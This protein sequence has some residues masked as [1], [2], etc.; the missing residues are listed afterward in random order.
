MTLTRSASLSS[1]GPAC[2]RRLGDVA[3]SVR[4]A[5][6]SASARPRAAP[7]ADCSS[8]ARCSTFVRRRSPSCG[9]P[10]RSQRAGRSKRCSVCRSIGS[11]PWRRHIAVQRRQRLETRLERAR[12]RWRAAQVRRSGRPISAVAKATRAQPRVERC[13]DRAAASAPGRAPR[14]CAKTESLVGEDTPR[15]RGGAASARARHRR[16][17]VAVAHEHRDV[18]RSQPREAALSGRRI[19]L[20]DRRATRR[21]ARRSARR[22]D[23]LRLR[24]RRSS[25]SWQNVSAGDRAGRVDVTLAAAARVDRHERQRLRR[26]SSPVRN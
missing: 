2:R 10:P 17:L 16:L 3:R 26:G 25:A 13:R 5:S 23:R 22:S 7:L 20:A 6:G 21:C 11:T 9:R 1:A 19:R 14:R 24:L 4:R 8:S 12:R 18:G 15:R